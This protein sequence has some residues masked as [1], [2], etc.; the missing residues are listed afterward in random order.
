[1]PIEC[2]DDDDNDGLTYSKNARSRARMQSFLPIAT[3]GLGL[4]SRCVLG[5][6]G[7]GYEDALFAG[8]VQN[9]I[10]GY[11]L[12]R[13]RPQQRGLPSGASDTGWSR[14]A[15]PISYQPIFFFLIRRPPRSTPP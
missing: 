12:T 4:P 13:L 15:N 8:R 7:Y 9:I 6:T 14:L 2:E 1:M 5:G 10:Q 3:V 11:N